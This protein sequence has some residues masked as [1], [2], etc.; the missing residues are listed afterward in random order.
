MAPSCCSSGPTPPT[1]RGTACR[2][3]SRRPSPGAARSP[4]LS[5]AGHRECTRLA[6]WPP[7]LGLVVLDLVPLGFGRLTLPA[8]LA[9]LAALGRSR[10]AWRS[11]LARRTRLHAPEITPRE[12]VRVLLQPFSVFS[13]NSVFRSPWSLRSSHVRPPFAGGEQISGLPLLSFR[14]STSFRIL[15]CSISC[16]FCRSLR[17]EKV[18]HLSAG[19]RS[20]ASSACFA[21]FR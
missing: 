15:S 7:V 11:L 10:H 2:P 12:V 13:W 5:L 9:A 3:R 21:A 19:S 4:R 6:F 20:L 8:A 1:R 14:P 16:E 18:V 17:P